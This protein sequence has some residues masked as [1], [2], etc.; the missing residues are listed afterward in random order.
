[1]NPKN[2]PEAMI[3]IVETYRRTVQPKEFRA[4][5]KASE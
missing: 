5:M 3:G 4:A 2:C 1:M